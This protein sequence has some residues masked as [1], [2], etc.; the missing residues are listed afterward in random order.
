[1]VENL[2]NETWLPIKGYEGLYE[3]SNLG[4]VKSL[5][6][7]WYA[8]IKHRQR[9][10]KNETILKSSHSSHYHRVILIK[11]KIHTTALIHRLVAK[12]FIENNENKLQVNHI[13]GNKLNNRVENLE[14]VSSRENLIHAIKNNLKTYKHKGESHSA[15][16]V[17]CDT[18]GITFDCKKDASEKL[19]ISLDSIWEVCRG[20]KIQVHGLTFRN[21]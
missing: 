17:S 5:K 7:V 10:E 1:M 11:N 12:H 19:G 9:N 16:K 18:L 13:D 3:I 20:R 2:E 15:V 21:I 6:K 8:A 14:W 4:R